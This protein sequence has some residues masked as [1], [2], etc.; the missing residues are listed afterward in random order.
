V[1]EALKFANVR[2]PSV[3]KLQEAMYYKFTSNVEVDQND[4]PKAWNGGKGYT[5]CLV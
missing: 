1:T 5:V 3:E 2:L 4:S